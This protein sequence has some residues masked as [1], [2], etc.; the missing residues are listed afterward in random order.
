MT[1][2]CVAGAPMYS[3]SRCIYPATLSWP[4]WRA[5]SFFEG[6]VASKRS[7][8]R[9]FSRVHLTRSCRMN[10]APGTWMAARRRLCA[11]CPT[12]SE[13][14]PFV[15]LRHSSAGPSRTD[16]RRGCHCTSLQRHGLGGKTSTR[17][18]AALTRLGSKPAVTL[19][20]YVAVQSPY[21]FRL[22]PLLEI[23]TSVPQKGVAPTRLA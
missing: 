15:R 6:H 2:R 12:P 1:R 20:V 18:P 5:N 22:W 17:R 9:D 7:I 19:P 13:R 3:V 16:L 8:H 4:G 11:R 23:G 14:F 10:L 21:N